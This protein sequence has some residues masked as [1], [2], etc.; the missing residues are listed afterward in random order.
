MSRQKTDIEVERAKMLKA[1]RAAVRLKHALAAD[2]ELNRVLPEAEAA[3]DK[4]VK[5]GELPDAPT[6]MEVLRG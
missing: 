2:E 3:F 6:L 4:A 1:I 5:R